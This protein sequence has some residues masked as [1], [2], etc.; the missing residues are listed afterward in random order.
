M[1]LGPVKRE[2]VKFKMPC[3]EWLFFEENFLST[4][5]PTSRTRPHA[6]AH[7]GPCGAHAAPRATRQIGGR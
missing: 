5:A 1:P 2:S 4:L 3:Q 7:R 6:K